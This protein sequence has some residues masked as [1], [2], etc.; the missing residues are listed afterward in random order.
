MCSLRAQEDASIANHREDVGQNDEKPHF[1]SRDI[2]SARARL[3]AS[4][5]PDP[6]RRNR[7]TIGHSVQDRPFHSRKFKWFGHIDFVE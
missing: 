5:I 1:D 4:R 6:V 7:A 2:E 3:D